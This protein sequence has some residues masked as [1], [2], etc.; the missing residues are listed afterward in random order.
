[1]NELV[2]IKMLMDKFNLSKEQAIKIIN[3]TK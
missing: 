1:M 3:K 2:K